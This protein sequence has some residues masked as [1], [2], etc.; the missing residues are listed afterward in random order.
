MM[1][2]KRSNTRCSN[3][4]NDRDSRSRASDMG[5]PTQDLYVEPRPKTSLDTLPPPHFRTGSRNGFG[6]TGNFTLNNGNGF[7]KDINGIVH[8]VN[9]YK[10]SGSKHLGNNRNGLNQFQNAWSESQVMRRSM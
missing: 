3:I 1:K 4:S 7:S 6:K 8:N 9:G 2:P 10:N 5:F